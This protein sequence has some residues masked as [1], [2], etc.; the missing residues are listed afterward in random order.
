LY[1]YN[2]DDINNILNFSSSE[3][4]LKKSG[5]YGELTWAITEIMEYDVTLETEYMI[6]KT[7]VP[8]KNSNIKDIL[9]YGTSWLLYTYNFV[10]LEY[11]LVFP[12]SELSKIIVF[13]I[14]I[15]DASLFFTAT[16]NDAFFTNN[17]NFSFSRTGYHNLLLK[18][19]VPGNGFSV[20]T[21]TYSI[22]N[23]NDG[24]GVKLVEP[25]SGTSFYADLE[26]YKGNGTSFY[27]LSTILDFYD[28]NLTNPDVALFTTLPT[29]LAYQNG[30]A[31]LNLFYGNKNTIVDL[32]PASVVSQYLSP[33]NM[34]ET[35]QFLYLQPFPV[36]SLEGVLN[37]NN[38]GNGGKLLNWLPPPNTQ[39]EPGG[40]H[41]YNYTGEEY[42]Q[43]TLDSKN[44]AKTDQ[45][46]QIYSGTMKLP[47][48]NYNE[49]LY[50]VNDLFMSSLPL[51]DNFFI[52]SNPVVHDNIVVTVVNGNV[53]KNL[54][55]ISL[56]QNA[57]AH[58]QTDIPADKTP[59]FFNESNQVA[60]SWPTW[61]KTRYNNQKNEIPKI[62][63]VIV[64]HAKGNIYGQTNYYA[65]VEFDN[66]VSLVYLNN[67]NSNFNLAQNQ[68]VATTV[69]I[70]NNKISTDILQNN[71]VMSSPSRDLYILGN[72]C[73]P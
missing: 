59:A 43:F 46:T 21:S 39:M 14:V 40:N 15:K 48:G 60:I 73:K 16:K 72:G 30:W 71:F 6:V 8:L 31:N 26:S 44:I 11:Q 34:L 37:R 65:F 7:Q 69:S 66:T 47:Y 51:G 68:G 9:A 28:Y 12:P 56:Y 25:S 41:Y 38:D 1:I 36:S 58:Y 19:I 32:T 24:A 67:E 17:P 3:L 2:Q 49:I 27:N 23:M 18:N 20:N 10:P 54:G 62:R 22:Y 52:N 29:K 70:Y 53:V 35:N 64:D 13:T 42:T 50:T 4:V 57:M 33:F 63:K 55:N 45:L 61:L 5:P